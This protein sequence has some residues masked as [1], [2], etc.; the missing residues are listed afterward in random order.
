MTRLTSMKGEKYQYEEMTFV[1]FPQT[2]F[3]FKNRVQLSGGVSGA[4]W[5]PESITQP[6]VE[7]GLEVNAI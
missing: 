7:G 5:F 1:S 4:G 2:P 6:E 3:R